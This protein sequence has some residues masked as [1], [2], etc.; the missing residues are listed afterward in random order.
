M[1]AGVWISQ[2][3]LCYL[4]NGLTAPGLKTELRLTRQP[5]SWQP[6]H[7]LTTSPALY[8]R[9]GSLSSLGRGPRPQEPTSAGS[10]LSEAT[11]CLP[12]KGGPPPVPCPTGC[13]LPGGLSGPTGT[14]WGFTLSQRCPFPVPSGGLCLSPSLALRDEP[15]NCPSL[16]RAGFPCSQKGASTL[17]S[18]DDT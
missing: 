6:R 1:G 5:L 10:G 3:Q 9:Q 15:P 7:R 11:P 4:K 2:P 12:Q 14:G 17:C 16:Q 13:L 18:V 8:A